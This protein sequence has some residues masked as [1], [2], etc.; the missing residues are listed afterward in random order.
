[1]SKPDFN[2]PIFAAFEDS[3]KILGITPNDL[4][5]LAYE[6]RL[7]PIDPEIANLIER[8]GLEITDILHN[9]DITFSTPHEYFLFRKRPVLAYIRDQRISLDEFE[10]GKFNKFHVCF[11]KALETARIQNR[12]QKRYIITTNTSGNF[13]VNI[14]IIDAPYSEENVYK[15]LE[16]CKDCLRELNWKGFLK[17]CGIGTEWWMGGKAWKREE[18]VKSFS[19]EEFLKSAKKDLLSGKEK[20]SSHVAKSAY[21]LSSTIKNNL[22]HK[23]GYKCQRCGIVTVKSDLE[24]HHVDH[25]PGNNSIQNLMVV[26]TNCHKQI[27]RAEGG[28]IGDRL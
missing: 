10:K 3:F 26:C 5:E 28:Y 13:L 11:C 14:D 2:S 6:L 22:K 20:L 21:T 4:E 27:H 24:I 1:M 8:G 9:S 19:I 18:I 12:L 16:V 15:R 23:C 17:F 7:P 25:N